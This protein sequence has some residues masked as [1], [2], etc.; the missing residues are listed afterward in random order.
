VQETLP[1]LNAE[2]RNGAMEGRWAIGPLYDNYSE[3]IK[4][5]SSEGIQTSYRNRSRSGA[6]VWC[7]DQ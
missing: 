1:M 2:G 5:A 4:E 7:G 3:E 6:V